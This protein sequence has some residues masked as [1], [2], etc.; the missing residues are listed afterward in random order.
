MS[1]LTTRLMPSIAQ[2]SKMALSACMLSTA[3]LATLPAQA[4]ARRDPA[5]TSQARYD[6]AALG[7]RPAGQGQAPTSGN[8]GSARLLQAA[9]QRQLLDAQS[10]QPLPADSAQTL[11]S[12]LFAVRDLDDNRYDV[13]G[14]Q[15]A[16]ID[17]LRRDME[18]IAG[19]LWV[20]LSPQ[21]QQ[22]YQEALDQIK[23]LDALS[24][25]DYRDVDAYRARGGAVGM[26]RETEATIR[27]LESAIAPMLQD[28]SSK[29]QQQRTRPA[30]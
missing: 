27:S 22:R 15:R 7:V 5:D 29:L 19:Q 13:T 21:S 9:G 17:A 23:R 1:S 12:L 10:A 4:Q 11:Q 26:V 3:L 2:L 20:H 30:R 25:T 18:R 14:R 16:G 24:N 28:V 8:T 6:P